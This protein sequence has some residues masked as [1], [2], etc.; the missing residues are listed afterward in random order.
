MDYEKIGNF[1]YDLRRARHL[2][3]KDLSKRFYISREAISKWERGISLPDYPSLIALSRFYN[4]TIN[5]ILAGEKIDENNRERIE[6]V[7][8][9]ILESSEKKIRRSKLVNIIIF[10]IALIIILGFYFINNYNSIHIYTLYSYNQDFS[11][12]DGEVFIYQNKAY[13]KL[14]FI[15]NYNGEVITNNSGYSVVIYYDKDNKKVLLNSNDVENIYINLYNYKDM[16]E[17]TDID[18]LLDNL[19]IDIIKDDRTSTMKIERKLFY[20]NDYKS[21]FVNNKEEYFIKPSNHYK[22]KSTSNEI[23]IDGK[24]YTLNVYG[25]YIEI[26]DE[27]G[28][29]YNYLPKDNIISISLDGMTVVYSYEFNSCLVGNC[30]EYILLL[31]KIKS[32]IINNI[33]LN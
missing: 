7:A 29:I 30:D 3:Q 1:L 19:F 11:L 15:Y 8:L 6:A 2:T 24:T 22:S 31:E 26:L 10:L 27:M 32:K 28:I 5:E 13:L 9:T 33:G 14:G 16:I 17:N 18:N 4:I 12:E 23:V 20:A 25:S 21:Y